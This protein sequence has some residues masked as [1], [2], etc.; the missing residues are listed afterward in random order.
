MSNTLLCST[1]ES[2]STEL[3]CEIFEFFDAVE[4]YR[5]FDNINSKITSILSEIIPLYFKITTTKDYDF[6]SSVILPKVKN[7]AMVKSIEFNQ[8]FQIEEFFTR[9]SFGTFNQLRYLSLVYLGEL[10]SDCSIVL[11]EQ[12]S[13]LTSLESLHIRVGRIANYDQCLKR[14]LQLLFIENDVFHSL[15]QLIFQ[16]NNTYNLLQVPTTTT[17]QTKLE[18]ITLPSLRL[19]NFLQFLPCIPY[20]RSI[21]VNRLYA[22]SDRTMSVP[23]CSLNFIL[24]NCV[25]LNLHLDYHITFEDVKL[26]L[27]KTP[28]L[29]QMKLSCDY[30]LWNGDKWEIL[31]A[32]NCPQLRRLETIF[33]RQYHLF[34]QPSFNELQHSFSTIFWLT[35]NVEIEHNEQFCRSIVRFRIYE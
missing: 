13:H 2:L 14:L 4:L 17:K 7:R 32:E 20:I 23:I 26:L 35:R 27:Q 34:N 9:Y 15:K 12:L 21:K 18:L 24:W 30:G 10:M 11:L 5:T 8:E 31:L 29:T 33:S 6:A 25:H 28:N 22:D 16:C 19:T 1:I 3:W